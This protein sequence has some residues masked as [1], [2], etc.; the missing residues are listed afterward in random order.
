MYMIFI[1]IITRNYDC[2][3][4]V[5]SIV[6]TQTTMELLGF[7]LSNHQRIQ[8]NTIWEIEDVKGLQKQPR[9]TLFVICPKASLIFKTRKLYF[10]MLALFIIS[11]III[12]IRSHNLQFVKL[13][14]EWKTVFHTNTLND[15]K[16]ECSFMFTFY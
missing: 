10:S 14:L 5:K 15:E 16:Q 2:W 11:I 7:L 1:I 8:K 12:I 9:W 3:P 13:A 4:F 6:I